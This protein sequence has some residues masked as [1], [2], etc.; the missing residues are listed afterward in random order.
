MWL[1]ELLC[2][3]HNI[4]SSIPCC[5]C[6]CIRKYCIKFPSEFICMLVLQCPN[7][8]LIIP[9]FEYQK[10]ITFQFPLKYNVI[11]DIH[12]Y[13]SWLEM[14]KN[15]YDSTLNWTNLWNNIS[16]DIWVLVHSYITF[17]VPK[18]LVTDIINTVMCAKC[19][20]NFRWRRWGSS[21]PG[22]RMRDPPL[23]PPS[24]PAEIF[25][26]TCLGGEIVWQFFW[27]TFSPNQRILST[28]QKKN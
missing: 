13:H 14:G 24:T 10:K 25:R 27:S 2:C 23:G 18:L 26:R 28:F 4:Y 16:A 12:N 20:E 11:N 1:V 17:C 21:L 19:I 7:L 3:N 8:K 15:C 5:N 9:G 6:I 22:L